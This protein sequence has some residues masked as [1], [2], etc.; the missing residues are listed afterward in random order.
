MAGPAF[1]CPDPRCVSGP[2][3]AMAGFVFVMAGL[4]SSCASGWG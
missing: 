4:G 2:A 1:V 3:F